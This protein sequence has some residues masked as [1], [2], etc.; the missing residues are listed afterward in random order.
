MGQDKGIYADQGIDLEITVMQ[1]S[2]QIAATTAGEVE[3]TAASGSS[4]GAA[5]AGAPLRNVMYVMG[6][7]IFSLY[8]QPEVRTVADLAGG[9]VAVTNRYATDD[10]ALAAILRRAGVPD[11]RVT[12]VT[13]STAANSFA[14]LTSKGVAGVVLS[15]PYSELAEREGFTYLEYAANAL[16]RDQSGLATTVQRIDQH[17]DEVKRMIRATLQSIAYVQDHPDEAT[18]YVAQLFELDPQLA[19]EGFRKAAQ[20]LARDGKLVDDFV[21]SETERALH[22][23][24]APSPAATSA[25]AIARL[26]ADRADEAFDLRPNRSSSVPRTS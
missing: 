25:L 8:G 21:I 9:A 15:P 5:I 19:A 12:R 13:A 11:D 26:I 16:K 2:T 22:V 14:A 17:P 10:Y 3:Y 1:P 20:A 18:A 7:L 6:D 23:R 4:L 24:N